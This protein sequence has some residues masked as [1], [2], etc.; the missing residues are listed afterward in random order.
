MKNKPLKHYKRKKFFYC[1]FMR[2][3]PRSGAMFGL[4]WLTVWL[5][6]APF[7]VFG[8]LPI[9]DIEHDCETCFEGAMICGGAPALLLFMYGFWVYYCNL[10]TVLRDNFVKS[11][12]MKLLA[13][14]SACTLIGDIVLILAV[15]VK[16]KKWIC[17]IF[18]LAAVILSDL[19]MPYLLSS[20]L[21][22]VAWAGVGDGRKFSWRFM[23]CLGFGGIFLVFVA[24]FCHAL[25]ADIK[26][27]KAQIARN[28]GHSLEFKDYL[29]R[30]N[31]GLPLESEVLKKLNKDKIDDEYLKALDEFCKLPVSR[32][33]WEILGKNELSS[34][35]FPI[36]PSFKMA[37]K[38][39]QK[40]ITDNPADKKL[41]ADA[42][43]KM[44]RLRD[45][46]RNDEILLCQVVAL[47]FESYRLNALAT[48]IGSGKYSE[49]ELQQLIGEHIP[50]HKNLKTAVGSEVM[51]FESLYEIMISSVGDEEKA[52]DIR[53]N[54]LIFLAK[55][56]PLFFKLNMLE[57]YHFAMCCYKKYSDFIGSDSTSGAEKIRMFEIDKDEITDDFHYMS[58]L[59]FKTMPK[60]IIHAEQVRNKYFMAKIAA[61]IMDFKQKNGKLPDSWHSENYIDVINFEPFIYKKSA[62][63]F[64]V[65]FKAFPVSGV[66]DDCIFAV[67]VK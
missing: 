45:W 50:W 53:V 6:A 32:I 49:S 7:V 24:V 8:L 4:A 9:W 54:T 63:G 19:S 57:D 35:L 21:L 13:F 52:K 36:L 2:K 48:V 12:W 42:N 33:R 38:Y 25:Q 27:F 66:K 47:A 34:T 46:M 18:A 1:F 65:S 31:S 26:N 60:V 10:Y 5:I 59:M 29:K 61:E 40:K 15:L 56:F 58:N 67:P 14:T 30:N 51:V 64:T 41:V 22:L 62:D 17:A 37:A 39:L 3:S 43:F 23:W 44:M 11:R 28:A 55:Y 16:K 20:L